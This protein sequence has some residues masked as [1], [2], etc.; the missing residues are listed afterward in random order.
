MSDLS[1]VTNRKEYI[2]GR[3]LTLEQLDD[4]LRSPEVLRRFSRY[5]TR[6]RARGEGPM[7]ETDA[8]EE[9]LMDVYVGA[10]SRG[11]RM[12]RKYATEEHVKRLRRIQND[13]HK[14][15]IV[16]EYV[17]DM[18][19]LRARL[20]KTN[21]LSVLSNLLVAEQ[22]GRND[23]NESRPGA[24]KAIVARIAAVE[25]NDEAVSEYQGASEEELA[26]ASDE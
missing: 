4:C 18:V 17:G 3:T 15:M 22:A 13:T 6:G 24:V 8:L 20:R 7:S 21:D 16:Q 25:G 1:S 19:D 11:F 12:Y 9:A 23:G 5:T 2:E 10:K 26:E 14:G